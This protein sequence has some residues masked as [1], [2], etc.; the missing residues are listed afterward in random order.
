MS[1]VN[2]SWDEDEP[3]RVNT[4]TQKFNP[5]QLAD[6]E[7]KEFLASYESE[8]DDDDEKEKRKKEYRALMES[9]DVDSDKDE[10][11]DV[12]MEFRFNP[13]LEDAC[14]NILEKKDNKLETLWETQLRLKREKKKR[15][16]RMNQKDDDD[17]DDDNTKKKKKVLE[18][19]VAAE[20]R[21]STVELDLLAANGGD[22]N[23]D[24]KGYNIKGRRNREMVEDK[25]IPWADS[26]FSATISDPN[27]ALDPTIPQF[28]RSATYVKQLAQKQNEDPT[29]HEQVK[30]KEGEEESSTRD[31]MLL[32]TKKSRFT[33]FAT[34]KSVRL[35]IQRKK[36]ELA[37]L[38]KKKAKAN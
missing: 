37:Q 5:D 6:L 23:K 22:G 16:R 30:A 11:N 7:L 33:E 19:K 9:G 26:S 35:K 14:K 1:K 20:E 38:M 18:E 3:H 34:V 21:R 29:S 32:A 28:T 17:D 12:D 27:Y 13:G 10:E 2:I 8:S 15:T 31:G 24:V 25:M 36:A 4:L